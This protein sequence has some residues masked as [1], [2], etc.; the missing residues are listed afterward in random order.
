M[1]KE[2]KFV[3]TLKT[4]IEKSKK[5]DIGYCSQQDATKEKYGL[6]EMARELFDLLNKEYPES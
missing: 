5:E 1:T 6:A 3:R 4:H 2:R